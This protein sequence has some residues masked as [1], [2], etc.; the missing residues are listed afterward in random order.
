MIRVLLVDDHAIVRKGLAVMLSGYD[1]FELAGEAGDGEEALLKYR[2]AKP[3][4]VLM[5]LLMPRMD[6]VSAI[7]AIRERDPNARIIV[8]TSFDSDNKVQSAL[9]AGATSYLLKNA[10][11]DE[12]ANAIRAAKNGKRILGSEAADA[13]VHILTSPPPAGHDLT[14]REREVL[15][16]MTEGLNN[17]QIADRLFLSVSTI[18]FHVGSILTKLGAGSRVEAVA[19]AIRN[20]LMEAQSYETR[21]VRETGA[22]SRTL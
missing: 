9:Q 8:L 1:E 18:K 6:G 15:A 10:T 19:L 14:E 13:L 11:A 17:K 3:D 12:L 20:G 4:V 16:L 2:R 5:D 7:K 22:K 21:L